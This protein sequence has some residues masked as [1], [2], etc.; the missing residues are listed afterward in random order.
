MF[1]GA[2]FPED[3]LVIYKEL[4]T[5]TTAL[6][7]ETVQFSLVSATLASRFVT[8]YELDGL[9]LGITTLGPLGEV[10]NVRL[11]EDG[12]EYEITLTVVFN[13][14]QIVRSSTLTVYGMC[15]GFSLFTPIYAPLPFCQC[16]TSF[17]F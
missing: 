17:H 7:G 15:N 12:Q 4:E 16:R 2:E 3:A 9:T 8:Q 5:E 1:V 14:Q 11:P 6:V 10:R 13:N